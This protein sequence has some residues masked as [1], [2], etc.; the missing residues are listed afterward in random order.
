MEV[1]F[2]GL[3][4]GLFIGSFLGVAMMCI[5]SINRSNEVEDAG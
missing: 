4:A 5:V 1:F 3:L 2:I